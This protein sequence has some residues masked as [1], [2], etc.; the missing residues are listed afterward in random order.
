MSFDVKEL[1]EQALIGYNLPLTVLFGLV[2]V[3]WLL[4]LLGAVDLDALDIDLDVETDGAD[5]VGEGIFAVLLRFVN[6]H[7]IPVTIVL[8]LL[9]VFMWAGAILTN[10]YFNPE[11][12]SLLA[13]AFL[14]VNLIISTLVVKFVTEPLRPFMRAIKDD[15]EL[16]EPLVGMSGVVKSRVMDSSFGQVEVPRDKGA[17]AL[18]N[19]ILPEGQEPLV[20]GDQILVIDFDD[21]LDKYLVHP[22]PQGSH[23]ELNN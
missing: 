5:G 7:D 6:A 18:L 20:R 2:V 10:Y 4:T 16:Q 23:S 15:G 14:L 8:S 19:A 9:S 12:N 3:F 22:A 17:P 11:Q 13:M 21:Q 1:W